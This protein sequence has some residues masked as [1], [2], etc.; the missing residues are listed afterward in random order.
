MKV[1][2]FLPSKCSCSDTLTL[3]LDADDEKA[4][5]K[6]WAEKFAPLMTWLQAQTGDLVREGEPLSCRPLLQGSADGCDL[7]VVIS[8]RLVTSPCAI[9]ADSMGY[10]ANV[11]R[12]MSKKSVGSTLC[13]VLM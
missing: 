4:Q 1:A 10:T 8:N 2:E 6:E 11:E 7:I 12:L 9:V 5:Q 13:I 3:D